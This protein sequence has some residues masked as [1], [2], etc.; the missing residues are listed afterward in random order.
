MKPC[1]LPTIIALLVS[2]LGTISATHAVDSPGLPPPTGIVLRDHA[3]AA[4][5]SISSNKISEVTQLFAGNT[6]IVYAQYF[7]E[8]GAGSISVMRLEVDQRRNGVLRTDFIG[9]CDLRNRFARG[10]GV[11]TVSDTIPFQSFCSLSPPQEGWYSNI[12]MGG[13]LAAVSTVMRM[14]QSQSAYVQIGVAN[15][16]SNDARTGD[17]WGRNSSGKA[18]S[19]LVRPLWF[20]AQGAASATTASETLRPQ[21]DTVGCTG[22]ACIRLQAGTGYV[23]VP[24]RGGNMAS[25]QTTRGMSNETDDN[26]YG[27]ITLYNAVS[28]YVA[29][30]Y[31]YGGSAGAQQ[32]SSYVS[33]GI[34]SLGTGAYLPGQGSNAVISVAAGSAFANG[35]ANQIIGQSQRAGN[36]AVTEDLNFFEAMF[37]GSHAAFALQRNATAFAVG[38]AVVQSGVN[39]HGAPVTPRTGQ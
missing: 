16:G 24:H 9:A 33:S 36:F 26:M 32:G 30:A 29:G 14:N 25:P 37:G 10:N 35:S 6:A 39:S 22:A 12:Q 7:P 38:N 3:A 20:V 19:Q 31:R 34:S 17:D 27:P 13:F 11:L 8:R 21:F 23:F 15:V 28:A 1:H 4:Y 18:A 2:I 5:L